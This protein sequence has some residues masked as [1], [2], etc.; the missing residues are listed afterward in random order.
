MYKAKLNAKTLENKLRE[1]TGND[2]CTYKDVQAVLGISYLQVRTRLNPTLEPVT[3][4][5]PH[6]FYTPH[7]AQ[8]LTQGR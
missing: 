3:S 1:H 8:V 5:V 2:F 7:V 6:K 4:S